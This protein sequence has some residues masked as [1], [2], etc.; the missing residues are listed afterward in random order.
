MPADVVQRALTSPS[1]GSSAMAVAPRMQPSRCA[2]VYPFVSLSLRSGK[3][4]V[5]VGKSLR[6]VIT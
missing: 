3:H 1:G 6:R 5:M 4:G 2:I